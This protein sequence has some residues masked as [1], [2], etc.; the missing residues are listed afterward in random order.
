MPAS[1]FG[2]SEEEFLARLRRFWLFRQQ[3]SWSQVGGVS[4]K[5][6][7]SCGWIPELGGSALALGALARGLPLLHPS[8]EANPTWVTAPGPMARRW[9]LPSRDLPLALAATASRAAQAAAWDAQALGWSVAQLDAQACAVLAAFGGELRTESQ[10]A[11]L[12]PSAGLGAQLRGGRLL[13]CLSRL[14]SWGKIQLI[15]CSARL[16]CVERAWVPL[17]LPR[18]LT[19][20]AENHA[21]VLCERLF[22]WLGIVPLDSL[23]QWSGLPAHQLR[24]F[25]GHQGYIAGPR[26]LW[27]R[28]SDWRAVEDM[29]E[30]ACC[31]V[32]L[33]PHDPIFAALGG[34]GAFLRP[35]Q[36]LIGWTPSGPRPMGHQ[37]DAWHHL[38]LWDGTLVGYWDF[39]PGEGRLLLRFVGGLPPNLLMQERA[40]AEELGGWLGQKLGDARLWRLDAPAARGGRLRFLRNFP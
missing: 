32:F 25:L 26:Q 24:S 6:L 38:V 13:A 14:V 20:P 12:I 8:G 1:L 23:C 7:T 4:H 5:N 30:P 28:F 33:S 27:G 18:D 11:S 36:P 19:I 35:R 9:W 21:E 10:L 29:Q 40:R 2:L 34:P 16:D 3:L 22:D 37:G 17:S 39:S 31:A 15:P